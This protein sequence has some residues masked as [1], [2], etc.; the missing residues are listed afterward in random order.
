MQEDGPNY[1][2]IIRNRNEERFIG[3][4]I[5]SVVDS[6]RDPEIIVMDNN[7][8]DDSMDIVRMFE[9][10]HD[11]KVG[12]IE[13]YSPGRSINHAVEMASNE[14]LMIL[15]AH[16]IITR[17]DASDIEEKLKSYASV[18]GKQIPVYKGR[19]ISRRYIW[20]NFGA[21]PKENPW[22]E[23][24]D[25]WFLHNAMACYRKSVL[26]EFPF[27]EELY[28]KEDRYWA[29]D[30]IEADRK[31]LYDPSMECTH[32]WTTNGATWKGIG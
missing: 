24:E 23:E 20:H 13:D 21:E 12:S 29:K 10:W 30:V 25:R 7:S 3:Y 19:R 17:F 14:H 1:S 16:C 11:I 5:Q 31:I 32:H 26:Q 9:K 15:S 8:S 6:L 18:F 4:A 27:D 2:V 28:G 22:A